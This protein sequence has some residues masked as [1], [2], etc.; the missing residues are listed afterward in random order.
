MTYTRKNR[1][2]KLIKKQVTHNATC[3]TL[4]DTETEEVWT[5]GEKTLLK[6]FTKTDKK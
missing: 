4:R 2:Y 3:Y 1:T 5:Y 6:E